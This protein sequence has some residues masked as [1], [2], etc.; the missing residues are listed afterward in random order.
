MEVRPGLYD[1]R[2]ARHASDEGIALQ[3]GLADRAER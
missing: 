2:V 1:L 3:V